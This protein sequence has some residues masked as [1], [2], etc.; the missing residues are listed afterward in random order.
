VAERHGVSAQQVTLAWMLALS[1]VVIPIPGST[2]PETI[3]DSA[4][5]VDLVL[6]TQEVEAL[7]GS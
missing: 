4:A 2:R 6:T 5:A 7:S 3:R 1:P